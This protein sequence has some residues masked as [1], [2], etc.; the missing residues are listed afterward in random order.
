MAVSG[1]RRVDCG[2]LLAASDGGEWTA[3]S[4]C[5]RV[6]G[7]VWMEASGWRR[8]VGSELLPA[9]GWRRVDGGE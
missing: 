8:V 5:R 4:C 1:W 9:C 3:A 6:N 2:E 7:G